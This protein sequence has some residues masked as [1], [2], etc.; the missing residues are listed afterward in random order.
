ML[1]AII[2]IYIKTGSRDIKELTPHAESK[3]G[4]VPKRPQ[5]LS[6]NSPTLL[7][8]AVAPFLSHLSLAAAPKPEAS[9]TLLDLQGKDRGADFFFPCYLIILLV[10]R[11]GTEPHQNLKPQATTPLLLPSR[12]GPLW[13]SIQHCSV[14]RS[15]W[16][17][18]ARS[19]RSPACSVGNRRAHS[20]SERPTQLS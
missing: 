2:S 11:D 19:L 20:C 16:R 10:R 7:L 5:K 4:G 12:V 6:Q 1:P 8:S 17:S 18:T 9:R 14:A 15:L 13:V 3:A